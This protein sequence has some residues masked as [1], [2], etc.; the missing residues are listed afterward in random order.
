MLPVWA[1]HSMS[2]AR[3]GHGLD[4]PLSFSLLT[5]VSGFMTNVC[6]VHV[7]QELSGGCVKYL[8]FTLSFLGSVPVWFSSLCSFPFISLVF[9]LF[10]HTGT[11][12]FRKEKVKCASVSLVRTFIIG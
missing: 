9:L 7:S 4:L 8:R 3:V 1:M 11:F 10:S 5:H 2:V 6:L 12:I